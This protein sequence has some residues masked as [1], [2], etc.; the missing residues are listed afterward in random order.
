MKVLVVTPS[1]YSKHVGAV[2]RDIYSIIRFLQKMDYE[3][4]LYT[5]RTFHRDLATIEAVAKKYNIRAKVFEPSLSIIK[6]FKD[7]I[8]HSW[9]LFDGAT[10]V[11]DQMAGD[12]EFK[13]WIN[14]FKPDVIFSFCSYSW[15]VLRLAKQLGIHS[16][17]RSH[18]F[19]S[20]FFWESLD[21]GQKFNPLNWLRYAAKYL[22]EKKAAVYS[23]AVA[24]LPFEQVE[25]YRRWKNSGKV[26]I[27][28]LPFL[29]LAMREPDV[30]IDK[31]QID[32]FYL[33]AHYDVIFHLRG[34]KMLIEDIAPRIL[35]MA[36]DSVKFH[37]CGAKLPQFLIDQCGDNVSYEGYVPDLDLFLAK[38]DAGVFPVMSG[39]TMK[40]KVFD[41][42]ARAFPI[43]I[44]RNCLGGYRLRDGEEVFIADSV[45]EFVEKI[46]L[47]RDSE[48]R[49]RLAHGAR[50]FSLNNFSEENILAVLGKA[51]Q[52]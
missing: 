25:K 15:P 28:T 22:E 13:S 12:Q 32:L 3:V 20:S 17:F 33:G 44:S 21:S 50:N 51:L 45:D 40:G 49:K 1:C 29:A 52:A 37:V 5:I 19:E 10:H 47:L 39:K 30:H 27:L 36:G 9:V 7:M 34:V 23:D 4:V 43:V 14:D 41:S 46:L 16:V 18:N 35:K 8:V 24:T 31:Q 42:L 38:M 2:Q 26:H 6:R 48:V 11:F